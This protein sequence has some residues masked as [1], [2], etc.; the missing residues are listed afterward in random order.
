LS[1]LR[2]TSSGCDST[3]CDSM[4]FVTVTRTNSLLYRERSKA[5]V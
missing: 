3:A 4:F 2:F 5:T 1:I